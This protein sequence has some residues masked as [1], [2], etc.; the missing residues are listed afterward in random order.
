MILTRRNNM[1]YVHG[2]L[3]IIGYIFRWFWNILSALF[4]FPY[5][6]Q[7]KKMKDYDVRGQDNPK[8]KSKVYRAN[9]VSRVEEKETKK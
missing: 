4:G 3:G 6:Q 1:K 8:P 7:A 2:L 9:K 5:E